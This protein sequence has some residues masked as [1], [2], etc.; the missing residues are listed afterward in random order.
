[1][2]LEE[3]KESNFRQFESSLTDEELNK[4]C[5]LTTLQKWLREVHNI[6]TTVYWTA[7]EDYDWSVKTQGDKILNLTQHCE[8]YEIA[9]EES[10]IFALN[11]IK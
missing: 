11:L 4:I 6:H 10:L 7:K 5:H 9:L 3:W 1:M 8:T 2:T